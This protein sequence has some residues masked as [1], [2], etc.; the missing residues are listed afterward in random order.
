MNG[1]D[2]RYAPAREA[3][4]ARLVRE[5]PLAWVFTAVG[6]DWRATLLPLRAEG[7]DDDRPVAAFLGHFA[8]G[9]PHVAL[10][11]RAPR[12]VLLFAGVHGYVSPSWMRDRTQ[13]PTWNYASVQY[14]VDLEWLEVA[15]ERDRVLAT[16][17]AD[18]EAG[19]D[20]AWHAG[21]MGPRYATLARRVVAFR[22]R[23]RERRLKFKL[24]QDERDDVYA[25][26]SA[27]LGR[28]GQDELRAWMAA[29]NPSRPVR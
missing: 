10:L 7:A 14:L 19:R 20:R 9:N 3:D 13:A 16:Q 12:A 5:H 1:P 15:G 2:E 25:D 29:A 24:G 11:R 28:E 8:A 26:I 27:A 18:H 22:A 17:V 4:V 6:D 23:V 21:E